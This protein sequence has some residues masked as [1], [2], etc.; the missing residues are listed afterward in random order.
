LDFLVGTYVAAR[1]LHF[2]EVRH[3]FNFDFR[4]DCEDYVHRIGRTARAGASGHAISYACEQYAYNLHEIE[5]YIE[6]RIPLS[7]Y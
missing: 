4:V 6:H 3:V 5:E 1:G 7:H 2:P